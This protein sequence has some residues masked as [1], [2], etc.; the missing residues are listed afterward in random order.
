MLRISDD[1]FGFDW[2]FVMG[3]YFMCEDGLFR[4]ELQRDDGKMNA[5]FPNLQGLLDSSVCRKI[6]NAIRSNLPDHIPDDV[7]KKF[8]GRSLRK[9]AI[10]ELSMRTGLTITNMSARTGHA[11]G[12]FDI[13]TDHSNPVT[14]FPAA[15]ALHGNPDLNAMPVLPRMDAVGARNRPQWFN[16]I[17]NIQQCIVNIQQ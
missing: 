11:I 8:S 6:A 2:Y 7:R 16:C 17:V 15:N 3:A 1:F 12:I 4:S 5:V 13:Y 14:S 10:T 9:G